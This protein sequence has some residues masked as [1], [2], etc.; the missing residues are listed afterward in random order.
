MLVQKHKI[1]SSIVVLLLIFPIHPGFSYAKQN[2]YEKDFTCTGVN[3]LST[4]WHYEPGYLSEEELRRDFGLFKDSGLTYVT[5]VVVWKYIEASPGTYNDEALDDVIRVC[6]YA[7]E[8]GLKVIIDFHTMMHLDS[9]TIPEWVSPRKFEQVFLDDSIREDWLNYLDHCVSYLD[10]VDNIHSWHMMNEPAR[11]EWACDVTIDEFIELW[12][13]MRTTFKA[14]SDKPV[15]IRFGGD[16][17]DTHF[18]RDPR[19]YE[20]CD[21][22]ALNW[23]EEFCSRELLEEM[24]KEIQGKAPVMISEFG[25]ETMDDLLQKRAYNDYVKFFQKIGI[26]CMIAWYWRAD[27]DLGTPDPPGTG[28]NLAKNIDGDPRPAFMKLRS[29]TCPGFA[30]PETRYGPIATVLAMITALQIK[31]RLFT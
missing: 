15:S 16:T 12:Q 25:Y 18:D 1:L 21:Y 9:F 6:E 30:I 28:F 14:H 4:H 20:V 27:Y 10:S 13:E 23:Y 24:V 11:N 5:L 8:Y 26:K 19:I 22:L 7:E 29:K 2:D 3:Y 17:F 31:R